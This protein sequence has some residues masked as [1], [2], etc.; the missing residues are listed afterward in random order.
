MDLSRSSAFITAA[1]LL[2]ALAACQGAAAQTPA[3]VQPTPSASAPATQTLPPT[4]ALLPTPTRLPAIKQPP[5]AQLPIQNQQPSAGLPVAIAHLAQRLAIPADQIQV[6]SVEDAEI[7]P[8]SMGCATAKKN[9]Q[10]VRMLAQGSLIVLKANG[11]EYVYRAVYD[12]VVA[13]P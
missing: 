11:V 9:E 5:A 7:P 8:L 2:M 6:V 1:M 10:P 4:Q 3:P 12:Q 13:C